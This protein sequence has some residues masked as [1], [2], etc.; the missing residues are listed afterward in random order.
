MSSK[1]SLR[2]EGKIRAFSKEGKLKEFAA[3]R[4]CCKRI[5]KESS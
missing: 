5:A 2:D 4:S 1:V 3:T